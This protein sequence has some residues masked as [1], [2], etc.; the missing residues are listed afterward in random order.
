[1]R[2][3]DSKRIW[4][5]AYAED[6]STFQ[7]KDFL[8]ELLNRY[9]GAE[10][11]RA[12]EQT[13]RL[14]VYTLA[15][16]GELR[17]PM[18]VATMIYKI[19]QMDWSVTEPVAAQSIQDFQEQQCYLRYATPTTGL[20]TCFHRDGGATVYLG[21]ESECPSLGMF[22][23]QRREGIGLMIHG[24]TRP[25]EPAQANH[26]HEHDALNSAEANPH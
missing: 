6:K 15:A 12:D 18:D 9:I 2:L 1:M 3:R 5:L 22:R 10:N 11:W 21:E 19:G 17:D 24:T 8:Y 16:I 25:L 23:D 13:D 20:H 14:F 4:R 26:V 7:P